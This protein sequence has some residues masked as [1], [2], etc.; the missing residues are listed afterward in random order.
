MD[1]LT[2][3]FVVVMVALTASVGLAG[4]T[5]VTLRGTV[6]LGPEH[7]VTLGAVATIEGDQAERL[8]ALTLAVEGIGPGRWVTLDDS[9]VREALDAAGA[10]VGSVVVVGSRVSITR[11]TERAER[12]VAVSDLKN[13]HATGPVTVRDHL[14]V[15]LMARF[16][17]GEADIRIAFDERVE[18]VLRTPTAGRVVEVSEIGMSGRFSVRV[19]VYER[20]SLVLT[21]TVAARIELLRPSAVALVPLRRGAKVGADQVERRAVWS[22][23]TMPPADPAAVVGQSLRRA[24]SPGETLMAN[25][26]EPPVLIKRGQ[27][28]SVRTIKGSVVVT[29]IARARH[30]ACEG[31]LIELETKD[32]SGRTFTARVAGAGRAVMNRDQSQEVSP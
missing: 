6:R 13:E 25:A 27:D 8:S 29:S 12:P 14:R 22:D 7:P 3:L 5:T 31:E 21:E 24:V 19:T 20:E 23:P 4:V 2:R 28:V 32:R 16:D 1:R 10:R 18:G 15:W 26:V 9:A 17:A 30:D 11:M